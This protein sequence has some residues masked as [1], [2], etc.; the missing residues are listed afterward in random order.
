MS[1]ITTCKVEMTEIAH[2]EAAIKHLGLRTIGTK[3]HDLFA[4]QKAEGLGILL[5]DWR[6]PLVINVKTGEAKYDNY[7]GGWGKQV[8]LDKLVQRYALAATEAKAKD[9]GYLYEERLQENG[10]VEVHMEQLY[11]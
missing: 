10:D 2:L 3:V 4:G 1:H 6:Y 8:E 7:N 11:A 5:D 9:E